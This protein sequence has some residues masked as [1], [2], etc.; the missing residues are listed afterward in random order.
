MFNYSDG[1]SL[2]DLDTGALKHCK[3]PLGQ[4]SG[5]MKQSTGN[6]HICVHHC[7]LGVAYSFM[8]LDLHKQALPPI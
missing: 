4:Q 2:I 1:I 8:A 5:Y 3:L 6:K 7:F